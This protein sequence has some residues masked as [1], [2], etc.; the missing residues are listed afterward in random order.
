MRIFCLLLGAIRDA[1]RSYNVV[2]YSTFALQLLRTTLFL[3]TIFARKEILVS[4]TVQN[5]SAFN[6]E[7]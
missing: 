4:P 5:N 1:G 2:L 3:A 6:T 7:E